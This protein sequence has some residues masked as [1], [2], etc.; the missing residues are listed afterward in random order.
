MNLRTRLW[1]VRWT[2]RR[3]GAF[4]QSV[5]MYDRIPVWCLIKPWKEINEE[6][7][8][9]SFKSNRSPSNTSNI[10]NG[11]KILNQ[12]MNYVLIFHLQSFLQ[13][14]LC[15]QNLNS[16]K[17]DG[18]SHWRETVKASNTKYI[19]FVYNKIKQNSDPNTR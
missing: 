19:L 5:V 13:N 11:I 2:W 3:C 7:S 9:R 14:K 16:W 6:G 4:M 18:R 15:S 1:A 17:I 8:I 12:K 10:M